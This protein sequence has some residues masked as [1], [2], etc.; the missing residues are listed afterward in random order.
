M[1]LRAF[2][3]KSKQSKIFAGNFAELFS[4]TPVSRARTYLLLLIASVCL[5]ASC[6]GS[7]RQVFYKANITPE[8]LESDSFTCKVAAVKTSRAVIIMARGAE[9]LRYEEFSLG[10]PLHSAYNACMRENGYKKLPNDQVKINAH[11]KLYTVE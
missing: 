8:K 7:A 1:K 9:A 10:H 4:S 6:S 3:Y 2:S 11:G 5:L